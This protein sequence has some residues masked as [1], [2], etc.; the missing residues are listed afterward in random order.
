MIGGILPGYL[1]AS[2]TSALWVNPNESTE[3]DTSDSAWVGRW[4]LSFL[5]WGVMGLIF[6]PLYAI[7]PDQLI[8]SEARMSMERDLGSSNTEH[9]DDAGGGGG[10]GGGGAIYSSQASQKRDR[11]SMANN[12]GMNSQLSITKSVDSLSAALDTIAPLAMAVDVE[13]AVSLF[14]LL[15]V[16]SSSIISRSRNENTGASATAEAVQKDSPLAQFVKAATSGVARVVTNPIW[17]FT[18][19]AAAFEVWS[20]AALAP[21]QPLFLLQVYGVDEGTSSIII[22]FMTPAAVSTGFL[23]GGYLVKRYSWTDWQ[24]LQFCFLAAIISSATSSFYLAG[25]EGSDVTGVSQPYFSQDST[26]YY[27]SKP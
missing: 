25:C 2:F 1:T 6:A 10:G 8:K 4:W 16:S 17:F 21:R 15:S 26:R 14:S 24:C 12:T 9:K 20:A 5:I 7:F 27:S 22:A 13:G 11:S 23:V 3:L 19:L 18:S